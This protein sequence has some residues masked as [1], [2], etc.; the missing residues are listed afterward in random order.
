MTHQSLLLSQVPFAAVGVQLYSPN[1]PVVDLSACFLWIMAVGTIVCASLW[2]EFVAM[3][4]VDERY[5]QL[6][7]K[8]HF[9]ALCLPIVLTLL[10]H[11]WMHLCPFAP[12]DSTCVR[13][14]S[15]SSLFEVAGLSILHE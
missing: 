7:R 15:G 1:R 8:V 12:V 6:T 11:V 4:H 5:N 2:T 3:E 9:C 14:Q 10:I 13:L